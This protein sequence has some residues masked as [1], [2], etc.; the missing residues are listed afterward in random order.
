MTAADRYLENSGASPEKYVAGAFN[1]HDVVFLGEYHR[2]R[3]QVEL[4][5]RLIPRLHASGITVLAT[6]FARRIDQELLDRLLTGAT[7]NE[8]L[9]REITFRNFVFWGYQEYVDVY[10]AAWQVNQSLRA[11]EEPFRVVALNNAPDWSVLESPEDRD[12]PE[13]RRAVWRGETEANWA[14]VVLDLIEEGEKVLVYSG[15]HHAFTGYRQPIYDVP[16]DQ[17]R[18]FARDRM[19]NHV[20][21]AI[22]DRA[23]TIYMHAPWVSAEGYGAPDVHPVDGAIDLIMAAAPEGTWPVAFDT[24]GT[25]FGG[26]SAETSF[27]TYGHEDF[28]LADFCDGYIFLE[29][30]AEVEG[31]TPIPNFINESNIEVARAQSPN[32]AFRDASIHRFNE[33]IA[34]DADMARRV[35]HLILR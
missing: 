17:F 30:F 7:W 27:Y 6:E 13:L 23:M 12:D 18:G 15:I 28:T 34:S 10:K 31:V 25:P 35:R 1:D 33:A 4:V 32:P 22:G 16:T 26:L 3:S 11:D 20:Y 29:P 21:R 24:A 14:A 9:A 8:E 19:G 2:I 5:A